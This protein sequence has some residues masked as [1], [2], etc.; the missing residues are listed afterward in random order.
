M[1]RLWSRMILRSRHRWF[2]YGCVALLAVA[3]ALF[4]ERIAHPPPAMATVSEAHASPYETSSKPDGDDVATTLEAGDRT[5]TRSAP[6][7]IEETTTLAPLDFEG[8]IRGLVQWRG[9]DVEGVSAA[10]VRCIPSMGRA[11][12]AQPDARGV[13]EIT[14]I[15][16]GPVT[17]QCTLAGAEART[18][19]TWLGEGT[20]AAELVF[21]LRRVRTI[22]VFVLDDTGQPLTAESSRRLAWEDLTLHVSP[23]MPPIGG[24]VSEMTKSEM[25][26]IELRWTGPPAAKDPAVRFDLLTYDGGVQYACL[27]VDDFVLDAQRIADGADKMYLRADPLVLGDRLGS[28]DVFLEA[29]DRALL[30]RAVVRVRRDPRAVRTR[31]ARTDELGHAELTG[32]PPGRYQVDVT[33]D[34]LVAHRAIVEVP[35]GRSPAVVR[36]RMATGMSIQGRVSGLDKNAPGIRV[37]CRSL[38]RASEQPSEA[39]ELNPTE[40]WEWARPTF[41]FRSLPAGRYEVRGESFDGTATFRGAVVDVRSGSVRDV[42]LIPE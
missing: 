28:L 7:A 11:V 39:D 42:V 16:L 33:R 2:V 36:M 10:R 4:R 37:C 21:E 15:P 34:G 3:V 41:E 22:R 24:L 25:P 31:T 18:Q 1:K 38:E 35:S 6:S 12:D 30:S 19:E 40:S 8:S 5:S 13:F 17:V 14:G 26:T 9:G 29:D 23:S 20:V 27:A 32:L